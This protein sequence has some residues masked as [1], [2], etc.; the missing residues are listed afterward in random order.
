MT[1]DAL[2]ALLAANPAL[3]SQPHWP[4]GD[5][6]EQYEAASGGEEPPAPGWWPS[7]LHLLLWN[8]ALAVIRP[9]TVAALVDAN[10][11]ALRQVR[12]PRPYSH[13]YSCNSPCG[14]PLLQL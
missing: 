5:S 8:V 10:P 2:A 6:E 11:E 1:D 12:T 9:A 4:H 3:A 13:A 7:P 14:E